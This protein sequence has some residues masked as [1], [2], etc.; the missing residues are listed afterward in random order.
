MFN[1]IARS[2]LPL[3]VFP[4]NRSHSGAATMKGASREVMERAYQSSAGIAATVGGSESGMKDSTVIKEMSE[5]I[6]SDTI[7]IPGQELE[8][9][10]CKL[11]RMVARLKA[12]R[13]DYRF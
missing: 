1:H 12:A 7:E 11:E 4:S 5:K 9:R 10:I 6:T 8:A 2:M 3:C 13:F